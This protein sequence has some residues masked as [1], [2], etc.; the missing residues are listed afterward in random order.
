MIKKDKSGKWTKENFKPFVKPIT[1]GNQS[2]DSD[3]IKDPLDKFAIIDTG[4]K[5]KKFK[6]LRLIPHLSEDE[7][8]MCY[9]FNLSLKDSQC[10]ERCEYGKKDICYVKNNFLHESFKARKNKLANNFK[11]IKSDKF[12]NILKME[13]LHTKQRIFR[14]F[15]SGD[16]P[17]LDSMKKIIKICEQLP[18]VNFWIPTSR[19]DILFE[20]FEIKKL[21]I[22]SNAVIRLSCPNVASDMPQFLKDQCKKWKINYSCTTLNH[23]IVNCHCSLDSQDSK[24]GSC[25]K[26][27]TNDFNAVYL[28]HNILSR[29][30][31]RKLIQKRND[32]K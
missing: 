22:P 18:S 23:K 11:L 5:K 26:C 3:Q 12:V 4:I 30:N 25:E 28:I 27:F 24:C 14:F 2:K 19:D 20:Y 21:K 29:S 16:F 13:I 17:D 1:Q 15:S 32:K 10:V 8:M 6:K 7:K 9:S 31:A